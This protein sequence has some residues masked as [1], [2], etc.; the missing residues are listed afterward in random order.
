MSSVTVRRGASHI[1]RTPGYAACMDVRVISIGAL[2][3][4]DLWN[5]RS[6]VRTGHTTTTLIRDGA[7]TMLVDPGLPSA[8]RVPR[9]HERAGLQPKDIT[10][11]YL[12]RFGGDTT[13]GLD[14]FEHATWW[15]PETE[16]EAVGVPLAQELQRIVSG[17]SD[18]GPA[19]GVPLRQALE[20]E[21]AVL[22]RTEPAPDRLSPSLSIFPMPGVSPGLAGVLVEQSPATLLI[23]G[24]AVLSGDHVAAGRVAAFAHDLEQARESFQD[25]LE[26]ADVLVC[27]RDNLMLN[28]VKRPF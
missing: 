10:H 27:G 28:P 8:A 26:I 15:L 7:L 5:E 16:R 13:R 11:V 25:A 23:A 14:A 3:A 24:D 20:R 21:I 12:T 17:E 22:S 2:A 4:N 9:L 18:L 1:V 19:G 6:A